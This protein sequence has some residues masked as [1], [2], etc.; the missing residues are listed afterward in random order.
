M[1]VPSTRRDRRTP[2]RLPPRRVDL[3]AQL[4]TAVC[5]RKV[6]VRCNGLCLG[7]GYPSTFHLAPS[8]PLLLVAL[9][10]KV[11]FVLLA[12]RGS[13]GS[14]CTYTCA[15]GLCYVPWLQVSASPM[16]LRI[17]TC[18]CTPC[19]IRDPYGCQARSG[20]LFIFP[21]PNWVVGMPNA[22]QSGSD[23]VGICLWVL[24]QSFGPLPG[25]FRAV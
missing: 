5:A 1:P 24:E 8:P 12:S 13:G 6:V 23:F 16:P 15:S 19:Q 14:T 21:D 18:R 4:S 22:Y 17:I 25:Q 2:T 9:S 11:S 3:L 20:H 7:S 10:T